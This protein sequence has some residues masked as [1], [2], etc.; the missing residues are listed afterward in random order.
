MILWVL[1]ATGC[2]PSQDI[3]PF[4]L[5]VEGGGDTEVMI[6]QPCVEGGGDKEVKIDPPC[7]AE[8]FLDTTK[9]HNTG[10]TFYGSM[11]PQNKSQLLSL[12]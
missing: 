6:D 4:E 1:R 11:F 10:A 8:E 7:N 2:Y 12:L 5:E 9:K 3:V